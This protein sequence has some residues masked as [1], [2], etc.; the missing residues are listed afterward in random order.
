MQSISHYEFFA[1]STNRKVTQDD[2]ATIIII[3]T[4]SS[5]TILIFSM[6]IFT[7]INP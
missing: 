3:T 2:S 1:H 5:N 4:T 6:T 7:R